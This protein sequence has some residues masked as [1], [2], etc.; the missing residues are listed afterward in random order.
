MSA[1]PAELQSSSNGSCVEK[2][3]T[4]TTYKII[5]SLP[6]RNP[7]W[8]RL[9]PLNSQSRVI[10]LE[11]SEFKIGRGEICQGD[12]RLA[13]VRVS[14][15]HAKIVREQDAEGR[16]IAKLYDSSSNGTFYNRKEVSEIIDQ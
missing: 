7:Y 14:N 13:D 4:K 3:L 8:A 9:T 12:L 5:N 11:S 10:D 16:V 2:L 6:Q 1:L 15:L